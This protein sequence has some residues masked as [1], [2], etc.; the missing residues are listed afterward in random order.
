MSQRVS[1]KECECTKSPATRETL[2]VMGSTA[3]KKIQRFQRSAAGLSSTQ[4][5]DTQL[6]SFH[7]HSL[8]HYTRL[9]TSTSIHT[10]ILLLL[11]GTSQA[12]DF[13]TTMLF[14]PIFAASTILMV[15]LSISNAPF[16]SAVSTGDNPSSP[17]H[18]LPESWTCPN[19]ANRG[20]CPYI[21]SWCSMNDTTLIDG[22]LT[23]SEALLLLMRNFGSRTGGVLNSVWY[24][25]IHRPHED[26]G[27]WPMKGEHLFLQS[28]QENVIITGIRNNS[29]YTPDWQ[30]WDEMKTLAMRNDSATGRG[31]FRYQDLSSTGPLRPLFERVLSTERQ[32]PTYPWYGWPGKDLDDL[33]S[34]LQRSACDLGH[35]NESSTNRTNNICYD[36]YLWE[37]EYEDFMM[38]SQFPDHIQSTFLSSDDAK[39]LLMTELDRICS[40]SSFSVVQELSVLFGVDNAEAAYDVLQD[41]KG[42]VSYLARII[43]D[44]CIYYRNNN[45]IDDTLA[46]LALCQADTYT[47]DVDEQ[48]IASTTT[49]SSN[50]SDGTRRKLSLTTMSLVI[51]VFGIVYK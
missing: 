18:P 40:D 14:Q 24:W 49:D 19:D 6:I 29:H 46:K 35:R 38:N 42:D 43:S 1:S 16:T 37:D 31:Y 50:P 21:M 45:T 28:G 5:K 20:T 41:Q 26:H 11:R 9:Y 2:D 13:Y 22:Q 3:R 47:A 27:E 33:E 36:R 25:C 12:Q 15:L 32:N 44:T 7:A 48:L 30:V 23:R 10:S 8:Q 39:D 17:P 51:L 34:N 4:G